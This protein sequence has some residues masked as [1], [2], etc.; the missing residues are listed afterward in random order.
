MLRPK[1]NVSKN[2]VIWLSM[3]TKSMATSRYLFVKITMLPEPDSLQISPYRWSLLFSIFCW[4]N[5][6]LW[7]LSGSAISLGRSNSLQQVFRFS[8]W[9]FSTLQLWSW[10][11]MLT[12]GSQFPS[13]GGSCMASTMTTPPTGT[14]ISV[15]LLSCR[16]WS[17]A[18]SL[19]LSW[20]LRL[21]LRI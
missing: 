9:P 10:L 3:L 14:L 7:P 19:L 4:P 1:R 12:C 6:C 20:S 2:I 13:L 21:L 16:C 8:F 5:L 18:L 11:E 15:K 17:T